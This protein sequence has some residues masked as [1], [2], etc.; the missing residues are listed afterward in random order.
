MNMGPI[1]SEIVLRLKRE[2]KPTHLQVINES[3]L[4]TRGQE[5]HFKIIVVSDQFK[6]LTKVKRQQLVYQFL[7][8]L[9]KTGLH[10]VN[11]STFTPEEWQGS[12]EV[13]DSPGCMTSK[14]K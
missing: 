12:P 8:D 3:H 13:Q 6:E 2:L 14:R 11:Q 1:E 5:T 9:F 4:H 7:S 10:A